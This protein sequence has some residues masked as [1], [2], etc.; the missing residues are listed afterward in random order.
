MSTF[1]TKIGRKVTKVGRII[2]KIGSYFNGFRKIGLPIFV[3]IAQC[4]SFSLFNS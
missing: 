3:T 2:T 4:V 1:V